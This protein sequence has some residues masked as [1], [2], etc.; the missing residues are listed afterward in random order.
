MLLVV[1]T[2]AVLCQVLLTPGTISLIAPVSL[3]PSTKVM[4]FLFFMAPRSTTG[5]RTKCLRRNE[6]FYLLRQVSADLAGPLVP[7]NPFRT[8][9]ALPQMVRPILSSL[10]NTWCLAIYM[11]WKV[12]EEETLSLHCATLLNGV[13]QLVRISSSVITFSRVCT[14]CF[15]KGWKSTKL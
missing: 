6:V 1:L 8:V 11:A 12:A 13:F 4:Y 2:V 15:R 3:S 7:Q 5:L 9:C 14:L 10:N